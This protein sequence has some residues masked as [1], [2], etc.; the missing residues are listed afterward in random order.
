MIGPKDTF[1]ISFDMNYFLNCWWTHVLLRS[2]F[3]ISVFK[4][5][6]IRRGFLHLS[7]SQLSLS[8]PMFFNSIFGI[9]LYMFVLCSEFN[10]YHNYLM[11]LSIWRDI[12]LFKKY[13]YKCFCWGWVRHLWNSLA[14]P[15]PNFER[16]IF[17]E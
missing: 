10:K 5:R 16:Y 14:Q 11:L 17:L 2:C 9:I 12:A 8:Q 4:I 1:I 3:C 15:Q 13:T 6:L 7:L